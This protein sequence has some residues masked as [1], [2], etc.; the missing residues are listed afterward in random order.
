M[1]GH[2]CEDSVGTTLFREVY[3]ARAQVYMKC[4]NEFKLDQGEWGWGM[5]SCLQ[6]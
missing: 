2:D 1:S 6:P 4:L 3:R 5:S